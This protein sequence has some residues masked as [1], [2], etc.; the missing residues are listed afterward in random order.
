MKGRNC[1]RW[2]VTTAELF[3]ADLRSLAVFR[4]SLALLILFD[5]ANRSADLTAHYTDLGVLPRGEMIS[6][7]PSGWPLSLYFMSGSPHV[8]VGLFL[9]AA[10]FAVLLLVGYHTRWMTVASWMLLAS[11]HVRNPL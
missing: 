5:L 1:S 8:Q 4:I 6:P 2:R 3:G 9:L 10:L 11:L 7:I